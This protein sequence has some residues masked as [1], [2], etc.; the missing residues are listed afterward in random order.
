MVDVVMK[1]N[2]VTGRERPQ[3]KDF[4]EARKVVRVLPRTDEIRKYLKHPGTRVGF[5][6]EGSSEWPN[7]QFTRRRIRDGDISIERK[8]PEQTAPAPI[9]NTGAKSPSTSETQ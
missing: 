4:N 1:R 7:D 9:E 5:L 2:A 6:A 3:E 8:E